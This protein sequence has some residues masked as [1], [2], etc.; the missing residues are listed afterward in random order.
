MRRQQVV[1][2]AVSA[3]LVALAGLFLAS[4]FGVTLFSGQPAQPP[5]LPA[6]A[7][8]LELTS[9]ISGTMALG[10]GI[11]LGDIPSN[12]LAG[13]IRAARLQVLRFLDTHADDYDWQQGCVYGSTGTRP[14]CYNRAGHGSPLD[15]FMA[16]AGQVGAQPLI[17]VN[18]EIDDPQQ[19]A[20][21]VAFYWQHCAHAPD[22]DCPDP[23]WEIG[24]SPATWSHFAIPLKQRQPS[25][26]SMATPDQYAALVT[27]YKA[28]MVLAAPYYRQ[29]PIKIVADEFITGATDESWIDALAHGGVDTHYAPLIYS[30]GSHTLGVQ[31]IVQAVENGYGDRPGVDAWL[32]SLR[33]GLQQFDQSSS[34]KIFIGRWSI[35]ANTGLNEPSVYGGYAQALFTAALLARVW[36][37]AGGDNPIA[38]AVEAPMFGPAQEPFDIATSA[39]RS[40]IDVYTLLGRYFGTHPVAVQ[41]GSGATKAGVLAAG[42]TTDTGERRLL[43]VN[44]DGK[45]AQSVD[46]QAGSG[47]AAEMWWIAPD[48]SRADGAGAVRHARLSGSRISIPPWSVAVVRLKAS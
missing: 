20:Q 11:G 17:A 12:S 36:D 32:E 5:A 25:D 8:V 16:F 34:I 47:S 21:L 41:L 40:A 24:D 15:Q 27:S 35:D 10:L 13:P 3:A 19:A 46:L 43:L 29:H 23:Y 4:I 33:E 22:Q 9:G 38:M 31:D 45:K 44:L 28:A 7:L 42:A 2:F 30:S 39:P 37:D 1:A 26:S 6:R 48:S 18:G 14:D